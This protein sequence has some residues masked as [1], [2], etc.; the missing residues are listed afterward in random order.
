MLFSDGLEE[1]EAY[2]SP[3][4]Q[5][6]GSTYDLRALNGHYH[7]Y[8]GLGSPLTPHALAVR[9]PTLSLMG[10]H[11]SLAEDRNDHQDMIGW[12]IRKSANYR[13]ARS[14]EDDH[15]PITNRHAESIPWS[16]VNSSAGIRN[17]M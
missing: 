6:G 3:P 12:G 16:I 13:C 11:P 10:S 8:R 17:L 9:S 7:C 5:T 4:A 2:F 1:V 15:L 14:G